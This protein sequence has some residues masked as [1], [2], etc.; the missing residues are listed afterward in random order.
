MDEGLN[1]FCQ[2][3]TEQ[4]WERNYP[5]RR[6]EPRNMV[7]YMRT[8][9]SLQTP[10]MTNSESVLQFGNNAYGKPATAL[11]ILRETVMG[12]ELFDYAFKTYATRWAYKH[13]EPADFFRTMEDASAVDLDWFWRGWF[14]TTDRCDISLD[15]VKS[16][17]PNTKNPGLES[18]RLQNERQAQVPSISAQRN[19][20][21]LKTTLVDEKPDLKDFYNNYDPLA[22]TEAD[23]QR[24]FQYLSTLTPQQQQRLNGNLNFYEL[25]L[26]NVGGLVMPVVIQMTYDDGSQELSTIPAEI[27]RKNN[28][29][30]NKI[31]ITPKNVVSFVI[32]PYQQ[33]ADTDLS[34]NAFPR[35]AAPTRFELFQ[36]GMA[37]NNANQPKNPMQQAGTATA[38]ATPGT[39]TQPAPASP[40]QQREKKQNPTSG[41]K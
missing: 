19:A 11:N 40:I 7:D 37:G 26:H 21:D 36:Q 4:E 10:I 23:K 1:T 41:S 32:D 27:W 39:T 3:L 30:V 15:A 34:N 9:K 24:Y 25:N 35:Q 16:Y 13:P 8:D 18:T 6:G 2:Y 20:T 31:I 5:S 14:Y 29:Q 22:V 28:E 17:K 38:P 33:T 12:R